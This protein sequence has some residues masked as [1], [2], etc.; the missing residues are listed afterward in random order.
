MTFLKF[1]YLLIIRITR[2]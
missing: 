2:E 1:F